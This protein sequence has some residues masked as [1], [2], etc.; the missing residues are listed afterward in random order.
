M[1]DFFLPPERKTP[2]RLAQPGGNVDYER[3]CPGPPLSPAESPSSISPTAVIPELWKQ[4]APS[5][6]PL[7]VVEGSLRPAPR[8]SAPYQVKC[9]LTAPGRCGKPAC[10]TGAA[11]TGWSASGLLWIPLE[12][13]Y[14][15]AFS[16]SGSC[17]VHLETGSGSGRGTVYPRG[18]NRKTSAQEATEK[19]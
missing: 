6:R 12:D 18:L 11:R 15:R 7:A 2:E 16:I 14:F 8:I 17:D 13:Q 9:F 5:P 19:Q 3:F 4:P 1:D 10:W